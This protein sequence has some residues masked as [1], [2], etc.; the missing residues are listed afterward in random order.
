MI[1]SIAKDGNLLKDGPKSIFRM[2]NR[3]IKNTS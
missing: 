2:Q 1:T 3:H